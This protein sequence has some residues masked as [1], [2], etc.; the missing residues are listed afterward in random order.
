[1]GGIL[2]AFKSYSVRLGIFRSPWAG[3]R[4]FN[5]LFGSPRFWVLLKNT[6]GISFYSL[7]VGFPIPIILSI[8][9]NET[10]QVH[11]KKTVQLVTYAPYFISTVVMVSM[12]LNFLDP[13]IGIINRVFV[14]LGGTPTNFMADSR[15][16]WSI[17]VWSGVWQFSGYAAIIFIAAL[18]SIDPTLYEAAYIDGASRFQKVLRIDIPSILPT[19]VI[20]LILNIGNLMNVGFEKIFLLQNPLNLSQSEVF[21]TYVYKIGILGA[22]YSFATAVGLFNSVVN[23]V[24]IVGVNQIAK[25]VGETSLW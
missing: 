4:Y 20:I 22:Q 7:A 14:L 17:Y 18:S 11:F 16:F 21:A 9:L 6:I 1:M 8:M 10:R 23:L 15:I 5:Q 13:R 24:L 19:I 12:V 2:L 3:L 25:R